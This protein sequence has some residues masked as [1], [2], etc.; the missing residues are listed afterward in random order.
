MSVIGRWSIKIAFEW[1]V[2]WQRDVVLCCGRVPTDSL[3]PE[4]GPPGGLFDPAQVILLLRFCFLLYKIG[5]YL[6]GM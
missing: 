1:T 3:S 2:V 5:T 4:L 6:R